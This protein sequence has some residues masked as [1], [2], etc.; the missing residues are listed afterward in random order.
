MTRVLVAAIVGLVGG[1][2]L[3]L[4]AGPLFATPVLARGNW[5]GQ[6]VPTAV[7]LVLPV[8]ALAI[9]AVRA[10]LAAV[11]AGTP[12]NPLARLLVLVTVCG[13]ALLGALDDVA[14]SPDE[15][16]FR[17]HVGALA[18]GRVTTGILKLA[19]GAAVAVAVVGPLEGRAPVRLLADAALVA[20]CANLGNLLDRAPGRVLKVGAVAFVALAAAARHRADLDGVAV[21]VGASVGL[22]RDDLRERL[23]LGDAGA[24][25]LGA[26]VGFG[27]VLATSPTTRTMAMVGVAA[28]NLAGE[29]VSFSRVIDAV[30]PLRALDRAGRLP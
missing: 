13:F 19:G 5:R 12:G 6:H 10:S 17:G 22:I 1:R 30:P 14:G 7:G 15:R 26:V 29:V 16:G 20:L 25:A 2:L 3:W 18:R 21:V 9:E 27:L 24:N 8:V 28:L 4:G 23:M 11:G